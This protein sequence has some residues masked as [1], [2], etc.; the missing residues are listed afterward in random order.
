LELVSALF[1][2]RANP[3]GPRLLL[4]HDDRYFFVLISRY[5]HGFAR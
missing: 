4:M 3:T 1:E 2:E 5:R